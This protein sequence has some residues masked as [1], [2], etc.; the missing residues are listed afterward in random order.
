MPR[1]KRKT[2]AEDLARIRRNQRNSRDRKKERV[3]ELERRVEQLEAAATEASVQSLEHENRT[4]RGLL[5]SVGFDGMSLNSY[6]HGPATAS[7]SG[8]DL[9]LAADSSEMQFM[10]LE[11]GPPT[12]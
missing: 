7:S 3:L 6:L 10:G 8:H 11:V 5:E 9:A 2:K 4:L 12:V 1:P